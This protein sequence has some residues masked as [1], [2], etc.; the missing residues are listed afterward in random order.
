MEF[1]V[2]EGGFLRFFCRLDRVL[3]GKLL[4][5]VFW[6]FCVRDLRVGGEWGEGCDGG[7][8]LDWVLEE[9]VKW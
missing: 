6:M 2:W 7:S 1:E 4:I 9:S 8:F 3:V 5:L